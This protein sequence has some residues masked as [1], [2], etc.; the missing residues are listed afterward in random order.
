M[1]KIQKSAASAGVTTATD[2]PSLLGTPT[3]AGN[4]FVLPSEPGFNPDGILEAP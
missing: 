2:M 4:T 1:S 3:D